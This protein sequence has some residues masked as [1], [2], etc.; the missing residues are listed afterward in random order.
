MSTVLCMT[1][2][3]SHQLLLSGNK[4]KK[5]IKTT[6]IVL[7]FFFMETSFLNTD[8]VKISIFIQSMLNNTQTIVYGYIKFCKKNII[9]RKL[10]KRNG[11]QF[12]TH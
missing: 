9:K 2:L 4:V 8:C 5:N 12:K 11:D 1:L 3:V 10:G 6:N 7:M